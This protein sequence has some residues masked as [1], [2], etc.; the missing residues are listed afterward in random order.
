MGVAKKQTLINPDSTGLFE[1]CARRKYVLYVMNSGK[2]NAPVYVKFF[3][4][5][6]IKSALLLAW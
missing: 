2:C 4:T 3:D 6:D 1:R 5:D